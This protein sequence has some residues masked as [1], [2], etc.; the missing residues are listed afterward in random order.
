[1]SEKVRTTLYLDKKV[2][3]RGKELGLNLSQVCE[4]S[5]IVA[6]SAMEHVYGLNNDS[7]SSDSSSNLSGGSGGIRTKFRA[8]F[9][10]LG[11]V[12]LL[13]LVLRGVGLPHRFTSKRLSFYKV[14]INPLYLMLDSGPVE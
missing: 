4:N 5:L 10:S 14:C 6:I 9:S 3:E 2:V 7:S 11:F 12:C 1:M 13:S 8:F